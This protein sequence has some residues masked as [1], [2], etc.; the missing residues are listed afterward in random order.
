[1]EIELVEIRDFLAERPPF[2]VLDQ[3][4]LDWLPPRMVIRYLRRNSNFPQPDPELH[5]LYVVRSGAIEI[6]DN[7]GNIT[8]RLG[9]G[10][11]YLHCPQD[12]ETVPDAGMALEDTL[13]YQVACADYQ[14]L[15]DAD[16]AFSGQFNS[17]LNARIREAVASS[18]SFPGDGSSGMLATEVNEL[19]RLEP[20]TIDVHATIRAAASLMTEKGV[21]SALVTDKEQL[22]G[23]V[24]DRDLRRHCIAGDVPT[25]D[26]VSVVMASG[27][28]MVP[29][30]TPLVTA[31]AKMSS[32]HVRHLPVMRQGRLY[33][34][35]SMTDVARHLSTNAAFLA[36]DIRRS[37][38]R[39]EL[40]QVSRKLQELQVQL[41]SSGATP[42]QLGLAISSITDAFTRR[43][44]ELAEEQLGPAPVPYTWM[45][46]GS[47]GRQEQTAHSDQDN[48]LLISNEMRPEDEG[49]FR[50]LAHYVCD[51]LNECGYIYCPGEAMAT[52]NQWRQSLSGWKK[53]FTDWIRT[54][55]PKA[56]M[57]SS[58]FFD[59]RLIHGDQDLFDSFQAHIL[60][61]AAE[62]SIFKAH[63]AVNILQH[64]PPLGFFRNFVLVH[65]GEHDDALDLKHRGSV[66]IIDIARLAA[67]AEGVQATNT[68]ERLEFAAGS[69]NLSQ[70]MADDLG[71]ALTYI[72]GLRIHHQADRIRRGKRPHNFLRPDT[73]SSLE[74][75]HLKDAFSIIKVMQE[76][77][78]LR[79]QTTRIS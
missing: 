5:G 72:E 34:M 71:H 39:Q 49:Y 22:V 53:L 61:E 57:L 16:P 29:H 50:E 30:N 65:G 25:S 3:E 9:E 2:N 70:Q 68:M 56:M 60:K 38:T 47:Q 66:P 64:R 55:S 46:A 20:I 67:L 21:S 78:E 15:Q 75:A 1:M 73:L 7:E 44:I 14:S 28:E 52:N 13:L 6:R 74:R 19:V 18:R 10:D 31:L 24:T 76:A 11:F 12:G 54:P 51:G 27:I 23:L 33:G 4:V 26:P 36:G 77:L 42:R 40:K 59:L 35:I 32:L 45:A 69:R 43:L 62:N 8:D 17:S 41:V 48:A 63:M 79:Y 58:I 37:K